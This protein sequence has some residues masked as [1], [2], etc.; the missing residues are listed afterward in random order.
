[1]SRMGWKTW[2][3]AG[4]AALSIGAAGTVSFAQQAAGQQP[5]QPQARPFMGRHLGPFGPW[6]AGMGGRFGLPLGQLGLT[7]AQHDQ[8]R[9]IVENHQAELQQVRQRADEARTALRKSEMAE[10]FNE[11]AIRAASDALNAATTDGAVLRARMR[12]EMLQVLTAEQ[13]AKIAQ[14]QSQ[15]EQRMQ[16]R[17]Q[18]MKERWQ[19]RQ[20]RRQQQPGPAGL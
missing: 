8:I 5:A 20:Q 11:G 2:V 9:G 15:R 13:R 14:L 4:V 19:N 18:R 12:S 10:P 3:T 6:G 17:Q 1:M 16:L 7:E